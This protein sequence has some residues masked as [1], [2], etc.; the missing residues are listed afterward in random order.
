[1]KNKIIF[2]GGGGDAPIARYATEDTAITPVFIYFDYN[3]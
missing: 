1:M 2:G 3:K